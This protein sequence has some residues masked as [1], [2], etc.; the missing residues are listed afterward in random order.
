M[1][2]DTGR[3]ARRPVYRARPREDG[4]VGLLLAR[5]LCGHGCEHRTYDAAIM[6]QTVRTAT[7]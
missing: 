4:D 2:T 7:E 1:R 3:R 6:T 5:L